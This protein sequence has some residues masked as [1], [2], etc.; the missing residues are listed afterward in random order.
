ML[1]AVD[2]RV[3]VI[4]EEEDP[5]ALQVLAPPQADIQ[6]HRVLVLVPGKVLVPLGEVLGAEGV[7]QAWR[8]RQLPQRRPRSGRDPSQHLRED[9]RDVQAP[10]VAHRPRKLLLLRSLK[11]VLNLS[12]NPST[13]LWWQQLEKEDA[14][15][16]L[17]QRACAV[18][19]ARPFSG[20]QGRIE[21]L[22]GAQRLFY[23]HLLLK[24]PLLVLARHP[25][26]ELVLPRLSARSRLCCGQ[27]SGGPS[28]ELEDPFV[29]LPR[30]QHHLLLRQVARPVAEAV[31]RVEGTRA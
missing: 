5:G 12:P 6:R 23:D 28:K 14:G 9:L 8:L 17:L 3:R 15:G 24:A 2:G 30:L 18:S 10:V 16:A 27:R 1:V 11:V 25:A 31:Q 4:G 26:P 29:A 22:V 7:A 20:Y 19:P 13:K 21:W